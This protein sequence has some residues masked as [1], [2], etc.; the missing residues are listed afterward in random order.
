[1]PTKR[2]KQVILPSEGNIQ[3]L[4]DDVLRIISEYLPYG[5]RTDLR[6]L[7]RMF[8]SAIDRVPPNEVS[9]LVCMGPLSNFAR[10]VRASGLDSLARFARVSADVPGAMHDILWY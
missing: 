5:E 6:K 10:G 7:N 1:M 8:R 3:M 2:A 9:S 4:P